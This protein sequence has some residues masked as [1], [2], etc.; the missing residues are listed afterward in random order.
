MAESL[1]LMQMCHAPHPRSRGTVVPMDVK[2]YHNPRCSTSRKTLNFLRDDG[3][4]PTIV[5][6]LKDTPSAETLREIFDSLDI[7]VHEG[8]RTQE[9]EY[10]ELSL[11]PDTPEE[12]LIQAIVSHP[13]LLQRPIVVSSKGARIARPTIEVVEEIL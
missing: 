9:A 7:P 13:R 6:Y 2:I 4:E 11:S 5:Q 12:E 1:A 10:A 8:I 3:V